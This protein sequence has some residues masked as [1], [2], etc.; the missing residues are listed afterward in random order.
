[1]YSALL[2]F[3]GE[4][5]I[6]KP[7]LD[8]TRRATTFPFRRQ[9][10]HFNIISNDHSEVQHS[11]LRV[12]LLTVKDVVVRLEGVAGIGGRPDRA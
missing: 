9:I 6:D 10:F 1:M 3:S 12:S 8:C 5:Y 4:A 7:F 11:D 2:A